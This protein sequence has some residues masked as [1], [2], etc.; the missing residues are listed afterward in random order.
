MPIPFVRKGQPLPDLEPYLVPPPSL[1]RSPPPPPP[2]SPSAS[3]LESLAEVYHGDT[4]ATDYQAELDSVQGETRTISVHGD[5]PGKLRGASGRDILFPHQER[6]DV[7]QFGLLNANHGKERNDKALKLYNRHNL[8][9]SPATILVLQEAGN[10]LGPYL[11]EAVSSDQAPAVLGPEGQHLH[12]NAFAVAE[13]GTRKKWIADVKGTT[14]ENFAIRPMFRYISVSG[15][16]NGDTCL[17]AVRSSLAESIE[18]LKWNLHMDRAYKVHGTT[19]HARSR[20]LVA[21]IRWRRPQSSMKE[22]TIA[23]VHIHYKTAKKDTGFSNAHAEIFN[24]LCSDILEYGVRILSGDFNMSVFKIAAELRDRGLLIDIAAIYPWF[25]TTSEQFMSDSGAVF[26]IGGCVD[27]KP[28]FG[29]EYFRDGGRAQIAALRGRGDGQNNAV[30]S[31]DRG[32]AD[33]D[34]G[35]DDT[36]H[37]FPKGQGYALSSYLPKDGLDKVIECIFTTSKQL[38]SSKAW[39]DLKTSLLPKCKQKLVQPALFDF[40]G[41]Q[42]RTGAHMP[43]LVF[44]GYTC[45]RSKA[46]LDAREA[47]KKEKQIQK[48]IDMCNGKIKAS[49]TRKWMLEERRREAVQRTATQP[50]RSR[51]GGPV[52]GVAPPSGPSV[53][54]VS[55]G[56]RAN[57]TSS[58]SSSSNWQGGTGE[59]WQ[60]GAGDSS[61]GWYSRNDWDGYSW[62]HGAT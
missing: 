5:G 21:K 32:T 25:N 29:Y 17:I 30:T 31:I 6:T 46:G 45:T 18:R 36:L 60:H 37:A 56:W 54:F 19:H 39:E 33:G 59:G 12:V 26:V 24:L 58:S 38:T 55:S 35:E 40:N 42:F 3:S 4:N 22:L 52:G 20:F 7:G 16:E 50:P 43:L 15:D 14:K 51:C 34:A 48:G 28:K 1:L 57:P 9:S 11:D 53:P 41:V 61:R 10:E 8:K 62:W 13:Q 47:K 23:N 27:V 44:L 49:A 2:R